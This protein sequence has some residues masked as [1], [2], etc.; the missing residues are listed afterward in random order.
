MGGWAQADHRFFLDGHPRVN[1]FFIRRA[2][3]D[4][5]GVLEDDFAYRLYTAYEGTFGKLQEAW[6]EYRKFPMARIRVGQFKAPFSLEAIYSA[7]WI[8]FIERAL[9]PTNLAPFEEIGIQV[10]GT[11]WCKSIEYAVGVFNGRGKNLPDSDSDKEVAG[12]ITV[13]PFR[14]C[15][16]HVFEN[17]YFGGSFTTGRNERSLAGLSYRTAARSDFLVFA[18]GVLQNGNHLR[19]GTELEWWWGPCGLSGEY[20]VSQRRGVTDGVFRETVESHAWYVQASYVICGNP[21][22]RNRPIIPCQNFD[23]CL[24]RWG[25]WE[26]GVRYEEFETDRH[27]FTSALV[28]GARNV[29]ALTTG[30]I[31]WPNRHIKVMGN[32]VHTDFN[33]KIAVSGGIIRGEDSL[34][35][36]FQYEF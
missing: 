31:W 34:I 20:L 17:L 36:R 11:L 2:R 24:C 13:Q 7:K 26:L 32:Y 9:G 4:I 18:P 5:R 14:D 28:T 16:C 6:L 33:E 25:A 3:L 27:G 22:R 23:P 19:W 29:D 30:I 35:C 10:F 8:R 12:R 21:W 15:T 1:D